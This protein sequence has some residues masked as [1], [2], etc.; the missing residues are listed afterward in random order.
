M[1]K[2]NRGMISQRKRLNAINQR[3]REI[4]QR[5]R[6][7]RTSPDLTPEKKRSQ[8]V[9]LIDRRNRIGRNFDKLY[10]RMRKQDK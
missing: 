3:L 1:M 8:L 10:Q 2:E 4:N 9:V 5:I 6:K 7:V